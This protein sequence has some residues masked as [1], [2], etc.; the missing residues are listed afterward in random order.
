M[1]Q[2]E[3]HTGLGLDLEQAF[4]NTIVDIRSGPTFRLVARGKRVHER[5]I[6]I[7]LDPEESNRLPIVSTM[8]LFTRDALGQD[9]FR[10]DWNGA[11]LLALANA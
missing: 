11:A 9:S 10:D 5:D 1:P 7:L 4:S 6:E 3:D 8:M 2:I